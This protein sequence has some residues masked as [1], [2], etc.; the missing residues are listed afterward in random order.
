MQ[1]LQT[2]IRHRQPIAH[3]ALANLSDREYEILA[4]MADGLSNAAIA[5][6]M[7]VSLRTVETHIRSVFLKLGLEGGSGDNRR[8]CAVLAYLRATAVAAPAA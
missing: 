1:D 7:Y 3:H 4:L 8:V 2:R 5:S 6:R